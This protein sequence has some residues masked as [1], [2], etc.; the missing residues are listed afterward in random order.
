MILIL[1]EISNDNSFILI[2]F[3]SPSATHTA[4]LLLP[5]CY[6][7]YFQVAPIELGR[8]HW[9][10]VVIDRRMTFDPFPSPRGKRAR[11]GHSLSCP[12]LICP[13]TGNGNWFPIEWITCWAQGRLVLIALT[14][15]LFKLEPL[16]VDD[17]ES[18]DKWIKSTVN[19]Y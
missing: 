9:W 17:F 6:P 11:S 4:T 3:Y 2:N 16:F 7:V 8:D 5:S 12:Q 10:R 14:L 18:I 1:F 13:L 19:N 15:M